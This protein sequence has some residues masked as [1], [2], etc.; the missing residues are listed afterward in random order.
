MHHLTH[1]IIDLILVSEGL[2]CDMRHD[3]IGPRILSEHAVASADWWIGEKTP[4][5][6]GWH[7]N[8]FLLEATGVE[9]KVN[10]EIKEL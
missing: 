2:D 9:E 4:R 5:T 1:S 6:C 8:N 7:F 10:S 3:S